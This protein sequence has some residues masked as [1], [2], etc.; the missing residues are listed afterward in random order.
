M[1]CN[2]LTIYITSKIHS[3]KDRWN[4]LDLIMTYNFSLAEYTGKKI[5]FKLDQS[6]SPFNNH[7]ITEY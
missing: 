2:A 1:G 6:R 5:A 3:T 4:R 7:P